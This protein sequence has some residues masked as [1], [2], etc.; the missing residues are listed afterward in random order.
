[1][2][3]A[4][5]R[6]R[7]SRVPRRSRAAADPRKI[8]RDVARLPPER[9]RETR[10]HRSGFLPREQRAR[11]HTIAFLHGDLDDALVGF[12]D[13]FETVA[14]DRAEHLLR[15]SRLT[16]RRPR[17]RRNGRMRVRSTKRL[18]SRTQTLAKQPR[19]VPREPARAPAPR[20]KAQHAPGHG[21]RHER[22]DAKADR[23]YG[24]E[25]RVERPRAGAPEPARGAAPPRMQAP[26]ARRN[27]R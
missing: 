24:R 1:M 12:C 17:H 6:P 20:P 2:A 23:R 16:G 4:L 14:F 25:P 11:R 27:A 7:T 19:R 26:C 9:P 21:K 8:R 22:K 5:R 13:E 18:T 15:P 3:V 10:L